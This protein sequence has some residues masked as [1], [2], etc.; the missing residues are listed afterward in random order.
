MKV[1]CSSASFARAFTAGTLTQLE[2]LDI[3][4]NELEVDGIIFDTRDFPR[5]DAEYLA[6]LKKSATDLGLTVAALA[7]GLLETQNAAARLGVA[8]ALGAPLLIAG[9][10]ERSDDPQAWGAFADTLKAASGAAKRTN[11]TLALRASQG[12]LCESVAD[13]KRIGKDVDSAWLRFAL[14]PLAL[15]AA[16]DP[17]ALLAKAVIAMHV[18]GEFDSFARENDAE[19]L[20]LVKA[21]ARFR[22]FIVLEHALEPAAA[23]TAYH[24]AFDRFAHLR[25]RALATTA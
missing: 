22:G 2:W 17:A 25:A 15:G 5:D 8:A 11:V 9:A 21:L 24:D 20:A 16:D 13:Y 1:A 18:L 23:T 19:A 6:Q 10:P 3:C 7:V 12:T 4:A 14:P